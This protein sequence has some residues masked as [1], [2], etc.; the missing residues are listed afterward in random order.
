MTKTA[1]A[2]D[3]KEI[4]DIA[5]GEV[6]GTTLSLNDLEHKLLGS[7]WVEPRVHASIVCAS[8][9]C[10]NLRA[11]AFLASRLNAQMDD[12]ARTW[13]GDVTKGVRVDED[14]TLSRIFLWFKGDFKASGGPVAWAMATVGR[15]SSATRGS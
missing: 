3:K 11:E 9:S 14:Q 8:A 7:T 15:R 2:T 10:P 4:W 1:P 12:Q 6:G 13:V 5:A